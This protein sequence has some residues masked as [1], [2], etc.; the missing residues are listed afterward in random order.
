[1]EILILEEKLKLQAK[2]VLKIFNPKTE[3]GFSENELFSSAGDL[4][5]SDLIERDEKTGLYTPKES[6]I[7]ISSKKNEKVAVK[8]LKNVCI[9]PSTG[10]VYEQFGS[11]LF[12]PGKLKFLVFDEIFNPN[13]DIWLIPYIPSIFIDPAYILP[14]VNSPSQL[15]LNKEIINHKTGL[16]ARYPNTLKNTLKM[17]LKY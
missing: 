6:Q 14:Q 3:N 17:R 12:D 16:T 8:D 9:S 1:M 5:R 2:K 13:P 4:L 7:L 10:I 15:R 11:V